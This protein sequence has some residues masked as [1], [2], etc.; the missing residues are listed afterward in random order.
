MVAID[1]KAKADGSGYTVYIH[2]GRKDTGIDALEWAKQVEKMG[3]GEILL[4]SMDTDGTKAGFDVPLTELVAKN[5]G[6]PVIASG[7]G[8]TKEHFYDIFT[9]SAAEAALAATL[10]HFRQLTIAEVKE[11]LNKMGI[12]VRM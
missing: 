12:P 6:I 8:G 4:T 7:G 11:Y 1:A 3:A 10:F 5:V 9:K 2:G